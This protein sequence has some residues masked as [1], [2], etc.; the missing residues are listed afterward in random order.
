MPECRKCHRVLATAELRRT[1]LG[2]LCRDNGKWSR[3]ARIA[4]ELRAPLN[5]GGLVQAPGVAQVYA[6][7][8][9]RG[10]A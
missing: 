7:E 8:I 1:K 4:L 6:G 10:Q 2:W 9:F 5:V 3:C